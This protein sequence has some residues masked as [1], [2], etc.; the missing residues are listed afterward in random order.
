MDILERK[1]RDISP[2]ANK[3]NRKESNVIKRIMR[4]EGTG[5]AITLFDKYKAQ[6][7]DYCYWYLLSTLW[8]SHCEGSDL[9]LWKR[10]FASS[11][12]NRKLSVMKPSEVQELDALEEK[13]T[14]YRAKRPNERDAI[15]YTLNI[16]FAIA[17]ARHRQM[18]EIHE[19]TVDKSNILA[20]FLRRNEQEVIILNSDSVNPVKT[21]RYSEK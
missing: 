21:I 12:H 15:A 9:Q 1:Q 11:R 3:P 13:V 18:D 8:V 19:Y 2:L 4:H 10:L 6:L 20:L 16:N 14:I 5:K 7:G 17:L